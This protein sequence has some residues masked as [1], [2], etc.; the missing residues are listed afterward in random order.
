M[1]DHFEILADEIALDNWIARSYREPVVI[2]KHSDTCGISSRAYAEMSKVAQIDRPV[3]LVT[4]QTE[5]GI[6]DEIESRFNIEHE[7]PQILILRN[8]EIVWSA[9]H[10]RVQAEAVAAALASVSDED[11]REKPSG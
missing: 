10:G 4:V 6:S 1:E 3:G 2:F 5:R 9:S 8:G 7:S 11:A